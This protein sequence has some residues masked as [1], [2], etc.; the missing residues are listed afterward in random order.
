MQA[1]VFY[2]N[3]TEGM[4]SFRFHLSDRPS[5][6]WG[7]PR[8]NQVI[9]YLVT[10]VVLMSPVLFLSLFRLPWIRATSPTE[11]RALSLSATIYLAS[12]LAWAI[13]AA[14]VYV[15]F[16]WNIVAYAGLAPIGYRLLG[17]RVVWLH[18]AFGLFVI[19]IGM[20]SYTITPTSL[21]GYRDLGAAASYGWPTLAARVKAQQ[22][23]H[24]GSFLAT[25]RYNYS[26]QLGFQLHQID[27]AAFNHTPS[28]NDYWWDKTA[29][30][31]RDAIIIADAANESRIA[32][33]QVHFAA[34]E[35]LEDVPVTDNLGNVIWTFEIWLGR[36]Y[37]GD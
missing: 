30:A 7:T 32:E 9:A 4:A 28:Q 15:Y 18:A 25:T 22:Q 33:A 17:R 11:G 23:A 21:F 20:L 13:I 2:W 26:A 27:V 37:S 16:H 29:H 3:I 10:M 6:N 31:G 36:G 34:V 24:L 12:T 1:P 14:Y 5:A 35:K 19:T 8:V